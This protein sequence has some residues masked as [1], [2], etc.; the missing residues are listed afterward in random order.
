MFGCKT[1]FV[2]NDADKFVS[3]DAVPVSTIDRPTERDFD[4]VLANQPEEQDDRTEPPVQDTD[5]AKSSEIDREMAETTTK[6]LDEIDAQSAEID[7]MMA[8]TAALLSATRK[9]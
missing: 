5:P 6:A 2:S 1:C 8:E 9:A 3:V 7:R 4:K